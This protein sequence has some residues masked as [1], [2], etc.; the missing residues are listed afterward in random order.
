MSDAD[1]VPHGGVVHDYDAIKKSMRGDEWFKPAKLRCEACTGTGWVG[2]MRCQTC[3]NP[4][5]KPCPG[6]GF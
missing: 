1:H 3:G 4:N 2:W 6:F 5:E